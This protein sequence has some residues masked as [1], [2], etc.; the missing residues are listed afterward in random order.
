MAQENSARSVG[1]KDLAR[2]AGVST[3]TL[4]HYERLGLLKK[5]PRTTGGYRLYPPEALNRVLLIRNALVFGFTLQE[6]ATVLRV[7]DMGGAPC[8]RVAELARDKVEGLDAQIAQLTQLRDSLKST[9]EEWEVRLENSPSGSR[10]GL[11]ETLPQRAVSFGVKK[12]GGSMKSLLLLCAIAS[13]AFV[14]GQSGISCPMHE[15]HMAAADHAAGVDA[16]GDH[17]MG[18]SHEKS[19]HHFLLLANGGAIEVNGNDEATREEIR[20]HLSHVAQMFAA[21]DFELPMFIHDTVPPG[22]PVMKAKRTSI[23]YVFEPTAD[24][25]RIRIITSDPDALDAVHQF[26]AFQIQDHRTGDTKMVKPPA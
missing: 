4:R 21:G 10:A 25:G 5:P 20:T 18:F 12:K 8:R 17:A 6:L 11:L 24:G 19:A 15:E 14:Y 9:M 16:R 23:S 22:V 3:D 7:R 2:A 26:L 13:S 1:S